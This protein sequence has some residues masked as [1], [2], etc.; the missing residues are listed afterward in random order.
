MGF[1]RGDWNTGE[2]G[3]SLVDTLAY[4]I[5]VSDQRLDC[6][7][8]FWIVA[9]SATLTP[10]SSALSRSASLWRHNGL[11][12]LS[13]GLSSYPAPVLLSFLLRY[14]IKL[15]I[16]LFLFHSSV[17]QCPDTATARLSDLALPWVTPCGWRLASLHSV[18]K[19]SCWRCLP[20]GRVEHSKQWGPP[21]RSHSIRRWWLEFVLQW[22]LSKLGCY[23][24]ELWEE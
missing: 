16:N 17:S 18:L 21:T 7:F 24:L 4:T 20:R 12:Y 19:G 10:G 1:H 15:C 2:S 5:A 9:Y 13:A 6:C 8:H 22:A 3:L 23:R 14:V 11:S